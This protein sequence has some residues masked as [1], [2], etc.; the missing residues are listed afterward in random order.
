MIRRRRKAPM[1]AEAQVDRLWETYAELR[2]HVELQ[3]ARLAQL[4]H[5]LA[6]SLALTF[7]PVEI[8]QPSAPALAALEETREWVEH[9]EELAELG[10][11][12]A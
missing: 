2:D 5:V 3:A 4:E 6:G 1:P 7:P 11:V 9:A 8:A 12:I 10:G